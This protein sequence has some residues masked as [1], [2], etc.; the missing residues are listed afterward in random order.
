MLLLGATGEVGGEAGGDGGVIHDFMKSLRLHRHHPQL[1]R[2]LFR[3]PSRRKLRFRCRFLFRFGRIFI[4]LSFVVVRINVVGIGGPPEERAPPA[5][6]TAVGGGSD[7]G[8]SPAEVVGGQGKRGGGSEGLDGEK[9]G[10]H[11]LS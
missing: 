9:V 4:F 11:F 1:P 10:R 6:A 5:G 3:Q 7:G 8:S 2:L